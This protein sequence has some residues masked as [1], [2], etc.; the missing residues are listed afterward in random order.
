M[1][2]ARPLDQHCQAA[3]PQTAPAALKEVAAMEVEAWHD[4]EGGDKTLACSSTS[5]IYRNSI[6]LRNSPGPARIAITFARSLGSCC[7]RDCALVQLEHEIEGKSIDIPFHL[8]VE[9][10]GG[11]LIQL[12]KIFIE[13]D[14]QA[15]NNMD[16]MFNRLQGN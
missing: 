9:T 1:F 6:T 5:E 15:T 3:E 2:K 4:L 12:R 13:H 16:A 11:N 10:L 14:F 8:F 7:P